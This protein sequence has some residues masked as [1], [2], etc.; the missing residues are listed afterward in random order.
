MTHPHEGTPFSAATRAARI[1]EMVPPLDEG[2]F[3]NPFSGPTPSSRRA[4]TSALAAAG[5]QLDRERTGGLISRF[6]QTIQQ[7]QGQG[8]PLGVAVTQAIAENPEFLMDKELFSSLD[9]FRKAFQEKTIT[10]GREERVI[11]VDPGSGR[12]GVISAAG[13]RAPVPVP[14]GAQ[15]QSTQGEPLGA[16]VPTAPPTPPDIVLTLKEAA[17]ARER[18]DT[19]LAD[20]LDEAASLSQADKITKNAK[21]LADARKK[22]RDAFAK[23]DVGEAQFWE[24]QAQAIAKGIEGD[25][26]VFKAMLASRMGGAGGAPAPGA[27]LPTRALPPVAPTPGP[28]QDL[29]SGSEA[30]RQMLQTFAGLLPQERKIL[31]LPLDQVTPEMVASLSPEG[32]AFHQQRLPPQGVPGTPGAQLNAPTINV[33]PAPGSPIQPPTR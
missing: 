33:L 25:I 27:S 3:L 30:A 21:A 24:A 11:G 26:D 9:T 13:P 16:Q 32:R 23:K 28:V 4:Q 8:L 2:F 22:A 20:K 15:L 10:A 31:L 19:E 6:K 5:S 14:A 7:K 29:S 18:G 12:A 1:K 17:A